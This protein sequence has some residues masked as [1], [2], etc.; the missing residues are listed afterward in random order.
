MFVSKKQKR[1]SV[2]PKPCLPYLKNTSIASFKKLNP[3]TSDSKYYS[4]DKICLFL[5]LFTIFLKLI[6]LKFF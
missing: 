1:D 4:V 5:Y 2:A 6:Y 3:S